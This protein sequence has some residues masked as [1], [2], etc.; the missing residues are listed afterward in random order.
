MSFV[1]LLASTSPLKYRAVKEAFSGYAATRGK[2]LV[3]RQ[4]AVDQLDLP[5][6]PINCGALCAD[7]RA[8]YVRDLVADRLQGYDLIIAI[9]NSI[10]LSDL[11]RL[12]NPA[13]G[14]D[15]AWVCVMDSKGRQHTSSSV[16]I[17]FPGKYLTQAR[18]QTPTD[19]VH[20]AEEAECHGYAVT[21]GQCIEQEYRNISQKNMMLTSYITSN[22]WMRH[23]DFGGFSRVDQIKGP[24]ARIRDKVE[25]VALKDMII[26][27][28]DFP[29]PGVL[30][31]G[32]DLVIADPVHLSVLKRLLF[33]YVSSLYDLTGLKIAGISS[34]GYLYGMLLSSMMTPSGGGFIKIAKQG[35]LPGP[36]VSVDY[37]T[38]YSQDTLEIPRQA[39]SPGDRVLIVDDLVATGGSME[40]AARLIIEAGGQ[41][42]GCLGILQ[43]DSLVNQAR[44]KLADLSL[45]TDRAIP[46]HV[47][48][49]FASS[50]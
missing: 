31:Q 28:T 13:L 37:G 30:F 34:R 20:L 43:V 27:K 25:Q 23:P 21:M 26:Q 3:I 1:V 35:K 18:E 15:R 9:E 32:L 36:T 50:T 6:Q 24:L 41:A 7:R 33:K 45:K 4:I 29:K 44:G 38:E 12:S 49:P 16:A 14:Q 2:K 42:V 17:S 46:L 22:D 47:L 8:K 48:L 5:A 40:A 19:Y 10:E 39:V 11:D